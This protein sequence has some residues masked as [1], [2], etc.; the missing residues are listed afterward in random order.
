M[1]HTMSGQSH[2]F[3]GD[4][5]N[6]DGLMV[7]GIPPFNQK[8]LEA[9]LF[10]L[11]SS[12][13]SVLQVNVGKI[14]NLSCKHCHVGAGPGRSELMNRETIAGCLEVLAANHIP[15]LDV[16]GGAPELNPHL[17]WFVGEAVK[18]GCRVIV[19]T[20]LTTLDLDRYTHLAEFYASSKVEVVASLPYYREKETDRQRGPGVFETSIRVLRRLNELGYAREQSPLELNL[21]Y[22]PGGAFLPPAQH[23]IEAEYRREMRRRYGVVFNSLYTIAN[24]PVGRFSG[25]L[26]QTGNLE[27]Y[28]QRLASA[29]NPAAAARVMCRE[30]VSVG[31][32]GTLYDC[33]FNQMLG[34]PCAPEAPRHIN[35]FNPAALR[36]RRIVLANHCYA[37]TAG[38][39][40][41]CGGAVTEA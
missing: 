13:L 6:T 36:N 32:D 26:Q 21:V 3:A 11:R 23:A 1:N 37:C 22:N 39:G 35:Q 16:T 31:W 5:V 25:F 8:M 9:G 33:D 7:A 34:L 15:T 18:L 38:A 14:C 28:L 10:P 27:G 30:Q 41:S 19:R 12:G 20:N 2:P 40:S 24:V 17:P 29:F 4:D